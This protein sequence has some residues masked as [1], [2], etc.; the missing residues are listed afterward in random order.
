[1]CVGKSC[2]TTAPSAG[3]MDVP[4]RWLW[5][6]TRV[7]ENASPHAESQT[8]R[9]VRRR[10]LP[11]MGCHL[12]PLIPF[13]L[14]SGTEINSQL[15]SARPIAK[16]ISRSAQSAVRMADGPRSSELR[17][18]PPGPGIPFNEMTPCKRHLLLGLKTKH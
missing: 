5:A 7:R 13:L 1:M 18:V 15:S 3:Y 6:C 17:L 16:H 14:G 10:Q 11:K 8:S 9:R 4:T 12:R 2:Y